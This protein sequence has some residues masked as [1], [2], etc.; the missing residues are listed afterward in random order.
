MALGSG[1]F[2]QAWGSFSENIL[3]P[4]STQP[5]PDK[6]ICAYI[7][8]QTAKLSKSKNISYLMHRETYWAMYQANFFCSMLRGR[9]FVTDYE[10]MDVF[11]LIYHWYPFAAKAIAYDNPMMEHAEPGFEQSIAYAT[12]KGLKN[13]DLDLAH[14]SERDVLEL[15]HA[16]TYSNLPA[17][18]DP[19]SIMDELDEQ[20]EKLARRK[21]ATDCLI[22]GGERMG[23][24]Y[25]YLP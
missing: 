1:E 11:E 17:Y 12:S 8:V 21:I 7:D 9:P 25:R 4:R 23:F 6:T 3:T 5:T 15:V 18:F 2:I 22:A 24:L 20:R 19:L 10:L 16:V 13:I 14:G